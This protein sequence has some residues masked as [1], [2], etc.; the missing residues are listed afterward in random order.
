PSTGATFRDR[1]V[2][3]N[4]T[5][6]INLDDREQIAVGGEN[7]GRTYWREH[8]DVDGKTAYYA[9][10]SELAQGIVSQ[11]NASEQHREAILQPYWDDEGIGV[12]RDGASVY[13]TQNFC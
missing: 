2:D 3:A 11:W 8:T 4:Y 13:V 7:I 9:T 10:P 5:C 12:V 1:Y 6:R